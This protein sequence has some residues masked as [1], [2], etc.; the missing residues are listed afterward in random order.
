MGNTLSAYA[1]SPHDID[2]GPQGRIKGI[3]YDNKA[4]RYAG[5]PYAQPPVCANRWRKPIQFP[6]THSYTQ[7]DGTAFDATFFRPVC[8][9]ATFSRGAEKDVGP[10]TY[11]EDCLLLNIWTPVEE[12]GETKKWP[13]VLWLHGGWFQLGDP[14]QELGM[15]PT[16][17]ISTGK[18]NAIVVGIGYRLNVFGF[19]AGEALLEDSNGESAGNF[20]LWDQRL[21]MEWVYKNITAF[22]GD[23]NNITLGGRSAGAYATHAQALYE[24][25]CE[26]QIFQ[27]L[28]LYSNAIP[29]QPKA[30]KD[31]N[32]QFDELCQ[33]FKVDHSLSGPE[34]VDKLRKV[35]YRDLVDAL[36]ELK[37]HTF[38]PVTDEL[39]IFGGF[40]EYHHS[41]KFAEQ[42]KKG[43][44]RILIGEVLN[45]ETLYATYNTPEPNLESLRLQVSNYY[46]PETT[47]RILQEYELPSS[48]DPNEWNT[49]F[50]NIIS[51]GQVR[52]PSRWLIDCLDKHGVSL[53][54]IWH[55]RIAYRLSFITDK[56]AP[57]SFGVAHAMD[58]PFW[59]FSILHGPTPAERKLMEDWIALFVAFVNDDHT[60][61]FGTNAIDEMKVATPEG[62]IEIQKDERWESLVKLGAVFADDK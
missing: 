47:D 52:A 58:K 31:V 23:V 17:L 44:L 43:R 25:R 18:L 9:Q 12:P 13:V 6:S 56:V 11:S 28:Y 19:L 45:E 50:G 57:R 21:A 51:D 35:S 15:N 22:N 2:L 4:R 61:E 42:F 40:T 41:G 49:L 48:E 55:Y 60:Y 27:R 24:F 16:E 29:A 59:N 1:E 10:E 36:K 37:N 8:P 53:S 33:Y 34:K 38:R 62:R 54:D 46:A 32:P 14:L 39:F 30:L 26:E 3:Q 5:V 7:S 20:G